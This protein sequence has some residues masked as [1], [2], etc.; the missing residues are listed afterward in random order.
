[1]YFLIL[2]HKEM[3]NLCFNFNQFHPIYAYKRYTYK[4][5]VYIRTISVKPN[6][7]SHRNLLNS[8]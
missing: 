6:Q 2:Q 4:K 1:M 8:Q 3:L 5:R 7:E